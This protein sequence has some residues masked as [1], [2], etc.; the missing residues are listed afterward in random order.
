MCV[1]H[2]DLQYVYTAAMIIGF[3]QRRQ[4]VSETDR[5]N[6][7]VTINVEVRSM[8]ESEKSYTVTFKA[9]SSIMEHVECNH[10]MNL[11]D[12]DALF[13]DF[14]ATTGNFDLCLLINGSTVLSTPLTLTIVND[15]NPE[16]VEC[17]TISI[18]SPGIAG[19]RDIFECFDDDDNMDMYFCLH[20]ICIED[21]DG[22]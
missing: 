2:F 4:T 22:L 20:E 5:Q 12:Y 16:P 7:S 11:L 1:V 13:G 14:N 6:Q 19:D 17:F 18:A 9:P 21:D 10:P 3:T 15:F 8:L